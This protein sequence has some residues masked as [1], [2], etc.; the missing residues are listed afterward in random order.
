MINDWLREVEKIAITAAANGTRTLGLTSPDSKS[1]VTTLSRMLAEVL[2][3]CGERSLLVDLSRPIE[4]QQ[5]RTGDVDPWRS[6]IS[7]ERGLHTLV[8]VPT[9]TTKFQFNNVS[10]LRQCLNRESVDYGFIVLDLPP[11]FASRADL[12]NPLAAAAVC[13]AVL[14]VGARGRVTHKQVREAVASLRGAQVNL[15]GAILNDIDYV[16]P[17]QEI[18]SVARRFSRMTPRLC[19]WIE[20]R[21]LASDMLR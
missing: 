6:I 21:L 1:G 14:M 10:W 17:G 19:K 2:T 9:S 3:R 13:D 8:A 16:S 4:V 20:R 5:L 15:T 12:I 11:I 7:N 18:A